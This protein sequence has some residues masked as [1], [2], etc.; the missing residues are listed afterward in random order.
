MEILSIRK[1]F[2]SDHSSTSYEFLAVDKPLGNVE[3]AAISKLSSRVTPTARRASFIYHS[4]FGDLPNGWK[5]LVEKYYDLMY[6]ESYGTWTLV[7]A[8]PAAPSQIE[9]LEKYVFDDGESQ[10]IEVHQAKGRATVVV[11][12][13]LEPDES[14]FKRDKLDNISCTGL[15][16]LMMQIR[17]QLINGDYRALYALW[18]KYYPGDEGMPPKPK[19]LDSG[20]DVISNFS[21]VLA[22]SEY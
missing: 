2:A 13:Y 15:F 7:F 9:E 8:F 3:K 5:P 10:V 21:S 18:E 1:G 22:D 11:Y 20:L 4:E 19:E 6:G 14:L 12:C 16:T 17:K